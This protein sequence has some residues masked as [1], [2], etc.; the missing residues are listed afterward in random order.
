MLLL[1]QKIGKLIKVTLDQDT[2]GVKS[3]LKE[4]I[5]EYQ[6]FDITHSEPSRRQ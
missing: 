6:P 2:L 5:P 1:H 4:I 3:K